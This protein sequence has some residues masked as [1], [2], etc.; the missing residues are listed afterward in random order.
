[1]KQPLLA[2]LKL[3]HA[4]ARASLAGDAAQRRMQLAAKKFEEG[5]EV[6]VGG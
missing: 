1:M 4:K 6:S 3:V 2:V 5:R